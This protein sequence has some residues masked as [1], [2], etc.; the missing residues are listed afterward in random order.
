MSFYGDMAATALSLLATYGAPVTLNRSS[1][2]QI[3]PVTG[4]VIPATVAALA[5]TGIIKPYPDEV[6]DGVRVLASDRELVLSNQ[7][8]PLPSDKPVIGGEQWSIVGIKTIKPDGV[9]PVVYF[10]QVRR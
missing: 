4:D 5:T 3:H 7:Q 10:A 2:G 6:I 8:Q 9:T 1:G